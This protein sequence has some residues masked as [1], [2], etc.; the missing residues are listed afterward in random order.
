M[1]NDTELKTE[2]IVTDEKFANGSFSQI[3]NT[4]SKTTHSSVTTNFDI[5]EDMDQENS[6]ALRVG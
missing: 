2:T 6:R 5:I 4:I 1:S 3:E